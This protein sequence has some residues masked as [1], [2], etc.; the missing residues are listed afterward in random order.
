MRH[1]RPKVDLSPRALERL[2][3]RIWELPFEDRA[4]ILALTIIDKTPEAHAAVKGLTSL[5][6]T[7]SA[8]YSDPHKIDLAEELRT[9]ADALDRQVHWPTMETTK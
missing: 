9:V 2:K 5:I 4:A 8:N 7:M 6:V 3:A 1:R